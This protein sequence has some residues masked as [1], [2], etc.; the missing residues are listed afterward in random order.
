MYLE[1][2]W[3]WQ[4][5]L[6]EPNRLTI[7]HLDGVDIAG[8]G[9]DLVEG[10]TDCIDWEWV[11]EE[12]ILIFHG[13]ENM[14]NG[15]YVNYWPLLGI[16]ETE[17]GWM[18]PNRYYTSAMDFDWKT[19]KEYRWYHNRDQKWK[20]V[21]VKPEIEFDM[22][23]YRIIDLPDGAKRWEIIDDDVE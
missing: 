13:K 4:E 7:V 9:L 23:P 17:A 21:W 18:Q 14:V 20:L 8:L 16:E 10:L 15:H 3:G 6:V 19:N 22:R 2:I 1:N 12:R 11:P 5:T